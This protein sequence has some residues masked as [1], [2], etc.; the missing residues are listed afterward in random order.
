MN[1][2]DTTLD[3]R[4]V[5]AETL[6]ELR[7]LDDSGRCHPV[8]VTEGAGAPLRCCLTRARVGERVVLLSYAPLRRWA[9]AAGCD[10]GAYLETGP[11]FVHADPCEGFAGGWPDGFHGGQRVV[12]AYSKDGRILGGRVGE[13]DEL[14][15]LA[16][17]L[18]ADPEIAV[19]HVRAVEYGCFMH[20]VRRAA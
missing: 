4:A 11:V 20:E 8:T 12:R 19:V 7:R 17:E 5:P 6:A 1:T 15:K 2:T 3:V 16:A 9:E 10:P 14:P 18:L 13:P